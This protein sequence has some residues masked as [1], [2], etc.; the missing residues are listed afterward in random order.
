MATGFTLAR[1]VRPVSADS[2]PAGGDG[3]GPI[4]SFDL[5]APP[6]ASYEGAWFFIENEARQLVSTM[7][8]VPDDQRLNI[9]GRSEVQSAMVARLVQIVETDPSQR[10]SQEQVAYVALQ[11]RVRTARIEAAAAAV[12]EYDLWSLDPCGYRPPNGMAYELS[13]NCSSIG[14]LYG[15]PKPPSVEFFV[16]AGTARHARAQMG[17][18][19][20]GTDFIRLENAIG[21]LAIMAIPSAAGAITAN[22]LLTLETATLKTTFI[23]IAPYAVKKIGAVASVKVGLASAAGAA[24]GVVVLAAVTLAMEAIAIS[25]ANAVRPGLVEHHRDLQHA[26]QGPDLTST[27]VEPSVFEEVLMAFY[28]STLLEWMTPPEVPRG[29]APDLEWFNSGDADAHVE[30]IEHTTV[31]TESS[32][33]FFTTWDWDLATQLSYL[34][35]GWF[36]TIRADGTI[37]RSLTLR[38]SDGPH[39]PAMGRHPRSLLVST[40]DGFITTPDPGDGAF[41]DCAAEAWTGRCSYGPSFTFQPPMGGPART[42]T[43]R[44]NQAPQVTI[45]QTPTQAHEGTPILLRAEGSDPEG[46]EV[47]YRWQIQRAECSRCIWLG[48][49]DADF[50]HVMGP[51]VEHTFTQDGEY[52][53]NLTAT[54]RFGATTDQST[55]VSVAN[56]APTLSMTHRG[57]T[58]VG[59]S[60]GVDGH[61]FDPGPDDH[62]IL[63]VEWGDGAV[64]THRSPSFDLYGPLQR[65]LAG[66]V[67]FNLSHRYAT[68]GSYN[69]IARVSDGS[70]QTEEVVGVVNVT[71]PGL[72]PDDATEPGPPTYIRWMGWGEDLRVAFTAPTDDGGSSVLG[73]QWGLDSHVEQVGF[74]SRMIWSSAEL[75]PDGTLRLFGLPESYDLAELRLRARNAVGAGSMSTHPHWGTTISAD[76]LRPVAIITGSSVVAEGDPVV[77]NATPSFVHP[78]FSPGLT[79]HYRW[80]IGLDGTYDSESPVLVAHDL[81]DGTHTI[82]LELKDAAGNVAHA[83]VEVT[84]ENRPPALTA[85]L[86]E[87]PIDLGGAIFVTGSVSDPG[88]DP[89]NLVA[90]G[91]VVALGPDGSF[92]LEIPATTPGL[93]VVSLVA[94]DDQGAATTLDLAASIYSAPS[95]PTTPSAQ[96]GHRT[97]TV[98]WSPGLITQ[99]GD[100]YELRLREIGEDGDLGVP[101]QE[102]QTAGIHHELFGM[103]PG[104]IYALQV[105]ACNRLGCSAWSDVGPHTVSP[106][107]IKVSGRVV[108]GAGQPLANVNVMGY[109]ANTLGAEGWAITDQDG[110]YQMEVLAPRPVVIHADAG[111]GSPEHRIDLLR[112][113]EGAVMTVGTNEGQD[114]GVGD[115]VLGGSSPIDGDVVLGGQPLAHAEVWA[116]A[117][118]DAWLPSGITQTDQS[119]YFQLRGLPEGTYRLMVRPS[120]ALDVAVSWFGGPSRST[121]TEVILDGE[122]VTGL[123]IELSTVPTL[124]GTVH[125]GDDPTPLMSRRGLR[126]RIHR[127]GAWLPIRT[128]EVDDDGAFAWPDALAGSYRLRVD[129]VGDPWPGGWYRAND[130]L[131]PTTQGSSLITVD[132]VSVSV[133]IRIP[134]DEPAISDPWYLP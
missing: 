13:F 19:V 1:T 2:M 51:D 36:V 50:H 34:E 95:V 91:E 38:Y 44:V 58:F 59:V 119:G 63:E 93:Q 88:G 125:A 130:D 134:P 7:H 9:W 101:V 103:G 114:L 22:I 124:R 133:Q 48:D 108:D 12:A 116:Y 64:D 77:L 79:K 18:G 99:S 82:G 42:I 43:K 3:G 39:D 45:T 107:W 15:S 98:S 121:A 92:S 86:A 96:D 49:A 30:T 97:T 123:D 66:Q 72:P 128:V 55:I 37:T 53:V 26:V 117:D 5:D 29:I 14:R 87:Q 112:D 61:F 21:S 69:I 81:P 20:V 24:V 35:Q 68:P 76:Q 94:T 54:D 115:L 40:P 122:P 73:Y 89:V 65:S 46:H 100:T 106:R 111:A 78:F 109:D 67:S 57:D 25:D 28:R 127:P 11:Q 131:V 74:E 129:R 84:V 83:Q 85:E 118:D 4:P 41:G 47:T 132:D 56:V 70:D 104:S 75:Q 8:G 71:D 23:K 80:D 31:P 102:H 16:T 6:P 17:T 10:S 120:G 60:T 32:G 105:R 33:S 27:L 52:L 62:H 126:V 90:E 110:A 113:A